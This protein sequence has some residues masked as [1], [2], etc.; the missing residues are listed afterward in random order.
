M[1]VLD[2]RCALLPLVLF[3]EPG[4]DLGCSSRCH[5]ETLEKLPS[6][7]ELQLSSSTGPPHDNTQRKKPSI[8]ELWDS[9]A[10]S[11]FKGLFNSGVGR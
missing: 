5:A 7:W 3:S 10:C 2:F 9:P 4:F 1:K 11:S 8:P 6:T